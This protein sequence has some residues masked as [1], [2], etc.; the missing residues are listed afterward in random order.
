MSS[1]DDDRRVKRIDDFL[2]K[3]YGDDK[4]DVFPQGAMDR[5]FTVPSAD[6][7]ASR[8]AGLHT[9]ELWEDWGAAAKV[10]PYRSS[11]EAIASLIGGAR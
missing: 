3:V 5:W 7:H 9:R 4:F 10:G 6:S 8:Q 11:D 1:Y 2:I